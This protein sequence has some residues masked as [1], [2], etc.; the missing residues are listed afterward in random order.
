MDSDGDAATAGSDGMTIHVVVADDQEIV[1]TGLVMILN[2]SPGIEVVGEAA[3]G[4]Q[5]V[6]LARRLRPDVC[7]F[8]IRMPGLDGI[9]ATRE[10]SGPAVADPMAV[11]LITTFDQDEHIYAALRAGARGFLLKDA[12]AAMLAQAIHAAAQGDALIAPSVTARLL[13]T[14]AGKPSNTPPVQP[15][16][17]LTDREEQVLLTVAGGRTNSEIAAELRITL[18]TVKSHIASLMTKLGVRN[19]V[20]IAMWAYETGRVRK[21]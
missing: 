21:N 1:R 5:A 9:A 7:L 8:D 13:N 17:P 10:L 11:V 14:F 4:R 6:D 18:S 12:G 2:A 16:D 3:D 15:V 19:R 20:E